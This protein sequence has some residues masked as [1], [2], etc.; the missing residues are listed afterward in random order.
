M[1]A[2]GAVVEATGAAV[3]LIEA[4]HG[5]LDLHLHDVEVRLEPITVVLHPVVKSILTSP[6]IAVAVDRMA[7]VVVHL[8]SE[9][10]FHD[11]LLIL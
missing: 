2:E 7:D 3:I 1:N 8:P 4:L 6:A 9:D 11:L 10:Q 5:I